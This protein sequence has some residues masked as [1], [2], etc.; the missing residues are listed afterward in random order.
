[1]A[2]R[3]Y[4]I[5]VS[6][7]FVDTLAQKFGTDYANCPE[8]LS[9]VVF[10]VPNR[11][12]AVSLKDAFIRFNGGKPVVLPRILPIGDINEEDVFLFDAD[13]KDLISRVPSAID[14]YERLFLFSKLICSRPREYGLAPMTWGQAFSLAGDLAKMLDTVYNEELNLS[15]LRKLVPEQ[16]AAHWQETLKFLEIITAYWPQILSE[17]GVT[18]ACLRKNI[19][20]GRQAQ[21]LLENKPDVRIVSAGITGAFPAMRKLLAA[22]R[23]LPRGEIYF[24]NLDRMLD[25][26][27][28]NTL[29]ENHPQFE[30]RQLL[31]YLQITRGDVKDCV[32]PESVE[33]EWLAAEIM[34][35]AADTWRWRALSAQGRVPEKIE[36][37]KF[38]D[39]KDS[40]QEASTIALILRDVLN[41]PEKTAALVTPD[42]TLARRVASELE[43]W[44]IKIDD[45]AGK[46]LHLLPTGIFL[47]LII[48]AVEKNISDS[49]LLSLLKNPLTDLG[50]DKGK[51][52]LKIRE[53]ERLRRTPKFD[54]Q[55]NTIPEDLSDLVADIT[56]RLRPLR[57]AFAQTKVDFRKLLEIHIAAAETLAKKENLWKGEDGRAAASLLSKI[58]QQASIIGSIDPNQYSGFLTALL[59]SVMVRSNY[60]S[61]PRIKILGP[62]EARYN[63][64]DTIIIGSVNE[65]V[66]PLMSAGDPWLSRPMKKEFGMPLPEKAVGVMA[67]DFSQLI[68]APEVYVTRAARSAGTPMNKSRWQLRLETVLFAC[69]YKMD[70]FY[71]QTY[72]KI[73][74]LMEQAGSPQK[75]NPPSPKPPLSARPRR[76]SASAIEILMRDPYEIYAAKILKLK[77][78]KEL[79]IG[80]TPSDYG[81]LIHKILEIFCTK[82][83]HELPV[84]AK[85]V[86][87]KIGMDAFAEKNIPAETKAF[88]WPMFIKTADWFLLQE[89]NYRK[90]ISKVYGEVKGEIELETAGGRFVLEARADRVDRT[91][92]GTIN[93]IDYKTGQIRSQKEMDAGYAPQL[94]LEGLIAAA[95]GFSGKDGK[96]PAAAVENLIYW[97]LGSKSQTYNRETEDLLEKTLERLKKLITVFDFEHNGYTA[98]PNPKHILKYAQYEHLA[99]VKEW[100]SEENDG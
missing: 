77:P 16:Y 46:P 98:R 81:T 73:G 95:G 42:R 37:L 49:V 44:K 32:L 15:D 9:E 68:C 17:R 31:D 19:L 69:G 54:N 41:T 64:F 12:T 82:Y 60:N 55:E 86:L 89:K 24:Y 25:E 53:W 56:E 48:S 67:A 72:I 23:A 40:R 85:E 22:V 35:P 5:P 33:R 65:G 97:Q 62:I 99:R 43:R 38:V 83:P 92:S 57:E 29:D 66:W 80:L 10:L 18:D 93:I 11:R 1:M 7:S 8:E 34:R 50:E 96:I 84:N 59:A 27:V 51:Q 76:L 70:D 4:N 61:H 14:P 88:W 87:V 58:L 75:I 13:K 30:H 47:R 2:D 63:H 74:A 91:L 52:R 79:D 3:L 90:E 21:K 45:S 39:C 28:W 36:G 26:N 100:A 71:D 78:L 94:P 6:C 20:I